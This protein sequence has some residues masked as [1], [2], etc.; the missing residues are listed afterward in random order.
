M[1]NS[2][3]EAHLSELATGHDVFATPDELGG[4]AATDAPAT[5]P[6][7][8]GVLVGLTLTVGC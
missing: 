7:C 1:T 5:S 2:T 3:I 6:F 8:G 4:E